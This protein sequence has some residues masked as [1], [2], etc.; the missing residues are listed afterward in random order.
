MS[1]II[2]MNKIS[3]AILLFVVSV[4]YCKWTPPSDHCMHVVIPGAKLCD[5]K[6]K[7]V[8]AYC[9][10]GYK[11]LR[12]ECHGDDSTLC[13]YKYA[14]F[15]KKCN[16]K[17]DRFH[18]KCDPIYGDYIKECATEKEAREDAHEVAEDEHDVSIE[19]L[20]HDCN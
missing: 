1:K 6:Y 14:K 12:E 16:G 13:G 18:K 19:I 11:A 20:L 4:V 15:D 2:K 7:A 8:D 3:I 17:Q 9:S 10:A 5:K